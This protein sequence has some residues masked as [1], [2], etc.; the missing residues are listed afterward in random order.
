MSAGLT[1][2][3]ETNSFQKVQNLS[4]LQASLRFLPNVIVGTCIS[5]GTD[6]TLHKWSTYV[7]VN[8]MGGVFAISPIFMALMKP[9][10]PYWYMAFW[11]MFML[12]FAY[13]G[14]PVRF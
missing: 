8:I 9:Q 4:A 10:W 12:P 6:A 5:F 2:L 7:Y 1:K 3:T 11:G 14:E 13:D